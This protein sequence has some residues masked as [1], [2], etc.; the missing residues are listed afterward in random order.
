MRLLQTVTLRSL[1]WFLACSPLLYLRLGNW[2]PWGAF[3]AAA[4]VSSLVLSNWRERIFKY[5]SPALAFAAAMAVV[6]MGWLV[7]APGLWI[8]LGCDLEM[9]LDIHQMI[10]GFSLVGGCI[11]AWQSLDRWPLARLGEALCMMGLFGAIFSAHRHGMIQQPRWMVDICV[12]WNW[13][14]LRGLRIGGFLAAL[15][16]VLYLIL[17]ALA[18]GRGAKWK[19]FV[20]WMVGAAVVWAVSDRIGAPAINL[21]R[22]EP[23]PMS[24]DLPPPPPPPDRVALVIFEDWFRPPQEIFFS[25]ARV[26]KDVVSSRDTT[27][28][29]TIKSQVHLLVE[30][31]MVPALI[32]YVA[33]ETLKVRRPFVASYSFISTLSSGDPTEVLGPEDLGDPAW[34]LEQKRTLVEVQPHQKVD[35]L[36]MELIKDEPLSGGKIGKIKEWLEESVAVSE[37]AGDK[38]SGKPL[39]DIIADKQPCGMEQLSRALVD[40]LRRAGIP[41]QLNEGFVYAPGPEFKKEILLTSQHRQHWAEVFLAGVGWTPVPLHPNNIL[42]K[43]DPPPQPDLEDLLARLN[44]QEDPDQPSVT[45]KEV[46]TPM[47]HILKFLFVGLLGLVLHPLLL[48][49]SR[50]SL[51]LSFRHELRILRLSGL[52]RGFG[53]SWEEFIERTKFRSRFCSDALSRTLDLV[54]AASEP[55]GESSRVEPAWQAFKVWFILPWLLIQRMLHKFKNK[56]NQLT[57]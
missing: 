36:V 6:L 38:N 39:Q 53:E 46:R 54:K 41:A 34:S 45:G 44:E 43:A 24:S 20:M 15:A 28:A 49:F 9:A 56:P 13:N 10:L 27:R 48:A 1:F 14:V 32:R 4:L 17:L 16:G 35:L 51:L 22:A 25:L 47:I 8:R 21:P 57:A 37:K 55:K 40:M 50:K 7:S 30:M 33:S 31:P 52:S 42:D 2:A 3:A 23:P 19:R 29:K 5:R 26:E 12:E 18:E 11:A